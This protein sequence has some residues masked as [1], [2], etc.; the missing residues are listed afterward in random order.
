MRM[1]TGRAP[2]TWD[3]HHGKSGC[4]KDAQVSLVTR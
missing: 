3:P 2:A 4:E 1:G